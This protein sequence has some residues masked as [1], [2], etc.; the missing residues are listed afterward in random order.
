MQREGWEMGMYF[1]C[2]SFSLSR[3]PTPPNK[4][5]KTRKE[6][7]RTLGVKGFS[8]IVKGWMF[9]PSMAFWVVEWD[10]SGVPSHVGCE[11]FNLGDFQHAS[12]CRKL[13]LSHRTQTK[14]KK[15]P[16]SLQRSNQWKCS[17]MIFWNSGNWTYLFMFT[18]PGEND[19]IWVMFSFK[20]AG[21]TAKRV[22]LIWKS[23]VLLVFFS[24]PLSS[25]LFIE[26]F[27]YCKDRDCKQQPIRLATRIHLF[28]ILTYLYYHEEKNVGK[29]MSNR[30]M[31]PLG[32]MS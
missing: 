11:S 14:Q 25:H 18:L 19:P 26:G 17:G 30:P 15:N 22:M 20:W 28:D 23:L 27:L 5:T 12:N 2:D 10:G 16:S 13:R 24:T 3:P 32:N 1:C 29:Y 7:G 8:L 6:H 4:K 31:D 9:I 21:L